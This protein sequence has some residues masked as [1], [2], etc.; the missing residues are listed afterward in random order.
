M[1]RRFQFNVP[2]RRGDTD[3]W[4]TVGTLEVTT[5][6][7][8]ALLAGISFFIYAINKSLLNSLVLFPDK[9][10]H[11]Q[12]WRIIT[13]P[14]VNQPGI[15]PLLTLVLFWYFGRELEAQMGRNRFL[16]MILA[17]V[18]GAGI[19]AA[20]INVEVPL[21]GFR[22]IEIGCF[23]AY[24]AERANA[25]FMFNIPAW[26]MAAVIV[27]MDV[28]QLLGDRLFRYLVVEFVI[29]AVALL[30]SRAYGLASDTPWVPKLNLPGAGPSGPRKKK[31]KKGRAKLTA[32][33]VGVESSNAALD[34][35]AQFE[36]DSLLDKISAGGM[37]SLTSAERKRLEQLSKQLRGR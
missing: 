6:V 9:V 4:F 26:V 3:P 19:V 1:A 17:M 32:V 36:M 5:T 15:W 12:I 7:L 2:D 10:L 29:I 34:I 22:F 31:A 21:Y 8:V 13:W 11:G 25:R 24:V 16:W 18:I 30:V 20:L 35:S 33:P 14:L 28:L 27:G 23:V 37:E